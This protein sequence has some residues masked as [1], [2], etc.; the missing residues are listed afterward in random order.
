MGGTAA[1]SGGSGD[2]A[3]CAS[4]SPTRCGAAA[5]SESHA[6]RGSV[7]LVIHTKLGAPRC[8]HSQGRKAEGWSDVIAAHGRVFKN[9]RGVIDARDK[10]ALSLLIL[11]ATDS[12]ACKSFNPIHADTRATL[13]RRSYDAMHAL[14]SFASSTGHGPQLT[15]A[16]PVG[17]P[18]MQRDHSIAAIGRYYAPAGA[19]GRA[20]A[21]PSPVSAGRPWWMSP[22]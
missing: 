6:F 20:C 11:S 10:M 16:L 5:G 9:G 7:L 13:F 15:G 2:G 22:R 19:S 18:R 1:R 21:A 12:S 14:I 17:V 3:R 8:V 4:L